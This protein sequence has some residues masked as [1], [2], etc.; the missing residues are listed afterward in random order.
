MSPSLLSRAGWVAGAGDRRRRG[1]A[2]S[3]PGMRFAVVVTSGCLRSSGA[4]GAELLPRGVGQLGLHVLRGQNLPIDD[5]GGLLLLE[6]H[7]GLSGAQES[8]TAPWR[9]RSRV[10]RGHVLIHRVLVLV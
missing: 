4:E 2:R 10:R 7:E 1:R 8:A 9:I 5:L 6:R 3:R